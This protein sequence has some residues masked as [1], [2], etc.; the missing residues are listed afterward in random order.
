MTNYAYSPGFKPGDAILLRGTF[1]TPITI[2]LDKTAGT[3]AA[4]IRISSWDGP[5][6]RA[7]IDL[8]STTVAGA[9]AI[10][11]WTPSATPAK[12][13]GLDIS[14]LVLIG[15]CTGRIVAAGAA[16]HAG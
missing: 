2:Q 1:S 3:A 11:I 5:S 4:P 13:L 9:T 15:A 10:F 7:T 14:D 12:G 8:S 6:S 16:H